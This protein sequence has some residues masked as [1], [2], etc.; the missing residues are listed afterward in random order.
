MLP[1]LLAVTRCACPM[2]AAAL[3]LVAAVAACG[4]GVEPSARC[5][6]G[7]GVRCAVCGGAVGECVGWACSGTV[8]GGGGRGAA[9]GECAELG[10]WVRFV[11]RE[12]GSATCDT[13][14]CGWGAVVGWVAA[15]AVW[16]VAVVPGGLALVLSA[17]ELRARAATMAASRAWCWSGSKSRG[18]WSW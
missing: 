8:W 1:L 3:C 18:G 17:A 15:G 2:S 16:S 6:G 12:G 5:V 9:V 13:C 11:L 10:V 4:F 14:C 7:V